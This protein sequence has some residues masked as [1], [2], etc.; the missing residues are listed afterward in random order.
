MD[1][2]NKFKLIA[3]LR[4]KNTS[5]QKLVEFL[6]GEAPPPD[7]NFLAR[8]DKPLVAEVIKSNCY[9]RVLRNEIIFSVVIPTYN[10]GERLSDALNSV[11]N[12]KGVNKAGVEIIVVDDGSE[13]D[14]AK[15]AK[16]F[17]KQHPGEKMCFIRSLSNHGPSYARNLGIKQARGTFVCFTDDDCVVPENWLCN[18]KLVFEKNPEIGGAGGLYHTEDKQK[19]L[20]K[21]H[22]W[23][24]RVI[25]QNKTASFNDLSNLCGNTANICYRK[26]V[27]ESC[28]GFNH[29]FRFPSL[30]DIELKIRVQKM[31]F[32]ILHMPDLVRHKKSHSLAMFIKGSIY[33]GWAR[34]LMYKLHPDYISLS[35]SSLFPT[36]L[37]TRH[38]LKYLFN[39][40]LTRNISAIDKFFFSFF[41]ILRGLCYGLGKYLTTLE[42]GEQLG[43]KKMADRNSRIFYKS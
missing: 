23:M 20:N 8:I 24:F 38:S 21:F 15:T 26:S 14:T 40:K 9:D 32:S 33:R 11:L 17:I 39:E 16:N 35:F 4:D 42:I 29:F 22:N 2:L 19:R 13:D 12:Q 36:S 31:G 5:Y 34:Y 6:F 1:F 7:H 41:I 37:L 18:F 3:I 43:S 28:G 10:G 27:L 30:E 25:P